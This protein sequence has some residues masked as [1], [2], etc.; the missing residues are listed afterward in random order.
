MFLQVDFVYKNKLQK[1]KVGGKGFLRFFKK[2]ERVYLSLRFVFDRKR[3]AN[4][5]D[6][7]GLLQIKVREIGTSNKVFISTGIKL[8]KKQ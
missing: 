5:T 4:N 3:V 6:S 8:F 2:K 7:Q 1:G